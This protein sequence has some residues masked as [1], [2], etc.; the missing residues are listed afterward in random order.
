MI[1]RSDDKTDF[2]HELL[3]TN[4]QVSDLRKAFANNSSNILSYQE[5]SYLR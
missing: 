4:K 1:G 5:L 2:P 3:L